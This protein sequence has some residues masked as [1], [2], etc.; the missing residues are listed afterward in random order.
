MKGLIVIHSLNRNL[1][2]K[3]EPENGFAGGMG[4]IMLHSRPCMVGMGMGDYGPFYG[5]PGVNIKIA[6]TAINPP[7]SKFKQIGHNEWQ[8]SG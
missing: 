5:F 3:A 6:R 1:T 2:A 8:F 4:E 7:G